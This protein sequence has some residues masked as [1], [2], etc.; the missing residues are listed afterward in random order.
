VIQGKV[1]GTTELVFED[2]ATVRVHLLNITQGGYSSVHKHEYK[3]NV[4]YV[5]SG[6]L[7]I[8]LWP[9]DKSDEDGQPDVTIIGP[10]QSTTVD[11]GLWHRFR[12]V[13]DVVCIEICTGRIVGDD[14][15]RRSTGGT[16]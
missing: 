8:A 6:K 14:I 12:A 10:G 11:V 13:S 15:I 4:F 16:F 5:M 1:W 7:E 3:A 9:R 2:C